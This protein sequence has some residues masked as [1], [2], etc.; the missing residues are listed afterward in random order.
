[1]YPLKKAKPTSNVNQDNTE[2]QVGGSDWTDNVM[3][4]KITIEEEPINDSINLKSENSASKRSSTRGENAHLKNEN[5]AFEEI[6]KSYTEESLSLYEL[7]DRGAPAEIMDNEFKSDINEASSTPS[8]E[9]KQIY[10]KSGVKN[11]P[12]KISA[13]FKGAQ[14]S[15]KPSN[16]KEKLPKRP[17][18]IEDTVNHAVVQP[19]GFIFSPIANIAKCGVRLEGEEDF[20][21][22][23]GL[24]EDGDWDER[25]VYIAPLQI[26]LA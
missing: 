18:I 24:L 12:L 13:A 8:R 15:Q 22:D 20:L 1:M 2:T 11:A 3:N 19:L 23:E 14:T 10:S 26:D 4:R 21:D 9:S 16:A 25:A 17:S 6:S 5:V 7:E